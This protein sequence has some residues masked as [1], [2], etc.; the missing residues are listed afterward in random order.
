MYQSKESGRNCFKLFSEDMN[1]AINNRIDIE[2][3]LR[4]ALKFDQFRLHYQLQLNRQQKVIGAEALIRWQHPKKGLIYPNDFIPIAENIELIFEIGQSVIKQACHQLVQWQANPETNQLTIAVNVSVK[5]FKQLSFVNSVKG[6]IIESGCNPSFLRM[7]LTESLLVDD[8]EET[9]RKMQD[10]K[11]IGVRFSLDDFGTGYSSLM[12]LKRL[13]IDELKIDQSFVRDLLTDTNDSVIAQTIISLAENMGL[14]VIAEGVETQEQF[15][16]L[17]QMG[18]QHFQGYL[19]S[20]PA[21]IEKIN[22]L[23]LTSFSVTVTRLLNV[24]Y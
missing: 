11:A 5:E 20:K 16:M 21:P 12:Y 24:V 9:I 13:P 3:D 23:L 6:I 4:D 18:C 8:I 19:F 1:I 10:L 22:Q 2:Q 15:N 14:T 17:L 7:E